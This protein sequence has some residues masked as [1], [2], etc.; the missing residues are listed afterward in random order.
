M[1]SGPKAAA[2][3]RTYMEELDRITL[4]PAV[5]EPGLTYV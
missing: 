2:G 4:N 1:D 3:R 5:I